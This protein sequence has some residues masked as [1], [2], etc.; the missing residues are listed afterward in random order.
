MVMKKATLV[1]LAMV[2]VAVG[3]MGAQTSALTCQPRPEY[4]GC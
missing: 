2:A 3:L 4:P 1:L